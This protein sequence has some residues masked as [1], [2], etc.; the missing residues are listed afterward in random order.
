MELLA[1]KAEELRELAR[2]FRARAAG[3]PPGYYHDLILQT[4]DEMEELANSL[5]AKGGTELVACDE[6]ETINS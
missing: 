2:S 5:A 3:C 1:A 4:A 6:D